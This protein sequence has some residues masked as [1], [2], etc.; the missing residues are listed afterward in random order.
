MDQLP[1]DRKPIRERLHSS[2]REIAL[3]LALT[4]CAVGF[5]AATLV[6]R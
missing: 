1:L 6:G 3:A 4:V 5:L 2:R